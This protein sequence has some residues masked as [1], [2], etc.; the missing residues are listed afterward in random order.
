MSSASW[1]SEGC[2]QGGLFLPSSTSVPLA[3]L[4]LSCAATEL[5][6]V[7]VAGLQPNPWI[8]HF[9]EAAGFR[10]GVAFSATMVSFL[11]PRMAASVPTG[12]PLFACWALVLVANMCHAI[13]DDSLTCLLVLTS[14]HVSVLL[15]RSV[16]ELPLAILCRATRPEAYWVV[17]ALA[18]YADN[19]VQAAFRIVQQSRMHGMFMEVRATLAQPIMMLL[20]SP[21][22]GILASLQHAVVGSCTSVNLRQ[23][24]EGYNINPVHLLPGHM[25][26]DTVDSELSLQVGHSLYPAPWPDCLPYRY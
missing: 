13:R 23:F 18:A 2:R 25:Q 15:S 7:Y 4:L 9:M 14:C 24:P 20:R 26:P 3:R 16:A 21:L 17:A 11:L 8:F 19:V 10:Y 1:L 22:L 12:S 6:A 5:K